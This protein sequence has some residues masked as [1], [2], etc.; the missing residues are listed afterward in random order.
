[1]NI[2]V[3]G[4]AGFIGSHLV[5]AL[6]KAGHKVVIFDNLSTGR[7][8]NVNPKAKFYKFDLAGDN[9]KQALAK[10]KPEVVFHLAAQLNLR[11]SLD[12]PVF[13]A[14][15]NV[16]G[17]LNLF[18]SAVKAG[19]EH[20]IFISTGGAMFN[21]G[22]FP[23]AETDKPIPDSPYGNAKLA[24][25]NYLLNYYKNIKG[26][27]ATVLRLANVYGPRQD[28]KGEAGV[29]AIFANCLLQRQTPT[30]NGDGRQT[31]DF[32]YVDDAVRAC[33]L[34]LEKKPE[35]VFH[36]GTG[37][38]TTVNEIA[39]QL[40]HLSGKK[41]TPKTAPAIV[42][43]ARRSV[44]DSRLAQKTLKWKVETSLSD[45]LE[46]TWKWFAGRL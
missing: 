34:S 2:L 26:I 21:Q 8:E 19:V 30:I 7:Q 41:V 24:I 35:G 1:M 6:I 10:E 18:E 45:G 16:I 17:S 43:E 37:K 42:G 44:L 23:S 14:K 40:I 32:I 20:I 36:I 31:R 11:R 25:E 46:K 27:K 29:V 3:T 4:G 12:N 38:E 13:D 33:L 15:Q 22:P 28:A 9:L 5:D 39:K